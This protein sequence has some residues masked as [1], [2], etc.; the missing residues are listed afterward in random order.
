LTD[1][2]FVCRK[3]QGDAPPPGG[4]LYQDD[5]VYAPHVYDVQAAARATV[6][7]I[8]SRLRF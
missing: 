1:D 8:R 7:R 6:G 4:P 3:I 2:C 5:L